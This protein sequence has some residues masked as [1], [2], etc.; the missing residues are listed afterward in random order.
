M[1]GRGSVNPIVRIEALR[2]GEGDVEL[3]RSGRISPSDLLFRKREPG[4]QR[5][6]V[7]DLRARHPTILRVR[8]PSA[9]APAAPL[10]LE[11]NAGPAI[12]GTQILRKVSVAVIA[13]DIRLSQQRPDFGR[14]L[15]ISRRRKM[16]LNLFLIIPRG[17]VGRERAARGKEKGQTRRK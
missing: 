1:T 16:A 4:A 13:F 14:K 10:E 12:A 11:R 8:L 9:P 17:E 6:I 5:R 7:W 2:M 3:R 15:E